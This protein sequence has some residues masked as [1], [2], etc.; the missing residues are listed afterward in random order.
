VRTRRR[1]RFVINKNKRCVTLGGL[2]FVDRVVDYQ[3]PGL[4][5]PELGWRLQN[6]LHDQKRSSRWNW[7]WDSGLSRTATKQSGGVN[8]LFARGET[9]R[10]LVMVARYWPERISAASG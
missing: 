5:R 4:T 6:Q 1:R 2:S 10:K 7:A 9:E 8:K 3:V